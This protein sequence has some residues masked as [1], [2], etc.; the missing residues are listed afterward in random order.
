MLEVQTCMGT[1]K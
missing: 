1:R